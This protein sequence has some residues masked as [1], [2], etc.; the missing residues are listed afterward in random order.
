M[1]VNESVKK[2]VVTSFGVFDG[3]HIGHQALIRRMQQRASEL[4]TETVILTFE[5]VDYEAYSHHSWLL[6]YLSLVVQTY[7]FLQV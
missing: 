5:V 3:V 7:Q 6:F 1:N 4:D 2:G